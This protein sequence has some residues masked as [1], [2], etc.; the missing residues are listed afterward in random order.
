MPTFIDLPW[1]MC[2]KSAE[3]MSGRGRTDGRTGRKPIV[4][5]GLNVILHHKRNRKYYLRCP[6]C[7][8]RTS[9]MV[10]AINRRS[11]KLCMSLF[12]PRRKMW[13]RGGQVAWNYLRSARGPPTEGHVQ[14][15]N[16]YVDPSLHLRRSDVTKASNTI[17]NSNLWQ[18][19]FPLNDQTYLNDTY[20]QFDTISQIMERLYNHW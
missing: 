1:T 2:K 8:P 17:V 13:L 7:N 3:N 10:D 14:L 5:S 18:S 19:Y 6:T 20:C 15:Q 16:I 9:H 11:Q 4:P 12:P